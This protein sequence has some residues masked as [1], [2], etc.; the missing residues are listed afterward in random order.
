MLSLILSLFLTT[1]VITSIDVQNQ[2]TDTSLIIRTSGL[3]VGDQFS[4]YET[5]QAI[6]RIYGLKLFETVE[7]ETLRIADGIKVKVIVQEFPILKDIKFFG[8]RKIKTKDF[9]EKSA[10]KTGEIVTNQKLFDWQIAIQDLYKEK[11]FIL[12]DIRIQ[13]T[14]IDSTNKIGL[15]FQID[16]GERV[17]IKQIDI[18]GNLNLT[19]K[20]IKGRLTNKEKKWY[21]KGLFKEEKFKEDL[22]KIAELYKENGYL[23][24]KVTDYNLGFSEATGKKDWLIITIYISE[25][26]SYYIGDITFEGE[27][28]ITHSDLQSVLQIKNGQQYNSKKVNQSLVELYSI[29]SEQGFIYAQITPVEDISNDTV[30]IKYNIVENEPARIRMVVIEGNERTADKVIRRQ[31]STLPGSVFKRSDVIRSQR[32]V[33]NLGFFSDVKLD[34]HRADESGAIDLIYKV[35]EKSSF[36]TVGA[37]ITYNAQDKL[38]GYVEL[39]QPNLFGKGQTLNLK[40]EKGGTKTNAQIGFTEPYLF[41]RALSAGFNLNYLTRAYNYYDKEEKSF[42]LNISRPLS[43][44]YAR[45]YASA[46][47]GDV[48]VPK[49]SVSLDSTSIT[50][51]YIKRFINHHSTTFSPT[52]SFTR[53]SRDYIYNPLSG[54]L[55]SYSFELSTIDILYQRHILDASFYFPMFKKF[56]LMTRSRFGMIQ[57]FRAQDTIPLYERFIPGGT[58]LDGVRGYADQSLG[59]REGG[60]NIGGKAEAIF[61]L[62]YRFRPSPQLAFLAFAD[63]GNAW[64]SI[65]EFNISNLKRGAGV[66][67]RLE[68][69]MLGLIGFDFGYGFDRDGGGKWEPHFQIGRT[70]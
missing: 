28:L 48:Y 13:K 11:G 37:G 20:K 34:Y 7:I 36:G 56:C 12:A 24:A 10:L 58:G 39:S 59:V 62:E 21:R 18:V 54:S 8:N 2:Y 60:Y 23:D 1:Q 49:S 22:E 69:P 5:E 26:T 32:D 46:Q 65:R 15:V 51:Q 67:V 47:I 9:L 35:Q 52:I 25:G 42:S 41:D 14:E 31:I 33:F 50:Y 38:S 61:S 3:K 64:N 45:I 27:S 17:K 70:F 19:D 68:I 44:D 29:Y 4:K 57:G 30:N 40:I 66:G 6:K 16:E 43:L 55:L 63:A 53:D